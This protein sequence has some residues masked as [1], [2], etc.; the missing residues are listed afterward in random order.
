MK[1]EKTQKRSAVVRSILRQQTDGMT[2]AELGALLGQEPELARRVLRCMP[3]AYI[4]RW[5]KVGRGF[6]A[7]WSVVIPPDNCPHPVKRAQR[8]Q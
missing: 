4:D 5:V 7:V 1:D 6:A 2:T 3:D 8:F